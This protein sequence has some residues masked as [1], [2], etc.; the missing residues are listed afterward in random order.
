MQLTKNPL[1]QGNL[2]SHKKILIRVL[3]ILAALKRFKSLYD[4]IHKIKLNISA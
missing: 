1:N 2:N 4:E 3:R